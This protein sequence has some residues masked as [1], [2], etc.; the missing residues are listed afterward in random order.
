[1]LCREGDFRFEPDISADK[2]TIRQ[3]PE[4]IML[5]GVLLETRLSFSSTPV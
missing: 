4:I 2:Q 3:T 1:M 5:K